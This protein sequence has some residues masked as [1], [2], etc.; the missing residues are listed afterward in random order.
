MSQVGDFRGVPKSPT[1]SLQDID[2]LLIMQ[3]RKPKESSSWEREKNRADFS[4]CLLLRNKIELQ[5][6]PSQKNLLNTQG[7]S[8][9]FQKS[10]DEITRT[11][12]KQNN[13][14]KKKNN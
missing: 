6:P 12:W 5:V 1:D 11:K 14:K 10:H 2:G 7:F 13:L 9:S 8:L 3:A 4:I